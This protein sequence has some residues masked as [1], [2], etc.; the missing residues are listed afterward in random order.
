MESGED[1]FHPDGLF[2]ARLPP[3]FRPRRFKRKTYIPWVNV[4]PYD[5][6]DH[7]DN[8]ELNLEEDCFVCDGCRNARL[9]NGARIN[10]RFEF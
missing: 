7:D 6:A 3:I 4:L 2:G 1:V 8:D 9:E 10:I 5:P